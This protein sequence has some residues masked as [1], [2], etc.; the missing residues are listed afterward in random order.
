[1][2]FPYTASQEQ[3]PGDHPAL[4]RPSVPAVRAVLPA[5]SWQLPT[6]ALSKETLNKLL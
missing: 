3:H 5:E 2:V 4:G 1:M 6:D